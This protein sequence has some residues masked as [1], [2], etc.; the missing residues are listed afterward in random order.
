MER[1]RVWP[2]VAGWPYESGREEWFV[3]E[4]SRE[5]ASLD[6]QTPFSAIAES[7]WF[8]RPNKLQ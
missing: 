3:L 6:E 5:S 8:D 7:D 1:E 2:V 4:E